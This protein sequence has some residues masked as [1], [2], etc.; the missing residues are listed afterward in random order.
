MRMLSANSQHPHRS[1]APTRGR[2][3]LWNAVLVARAWQRAHVLLR[4]IQATD[5]I[6]R[7]YCRVFFDAEPLSSLCQKRAS[8][9]SL[10][11][12]QRSAVR[13]VYHFT[14][15]GQLS[16]TRGSPQVWGHSS[17]TTRPP[18]S[19]RQTNRESAP[20]KAFSHPHFLCTYNRSLV[21]QNTT[22]RYYYYC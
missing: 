9:G 2:E 6:T 10:L 13:S 16:Y 22:H 19:H 7:A 11:P 5:D 18:A 1:C 20:K 4:E 15:C 8:S 3:S 12:P 21:S 17:C 14:A